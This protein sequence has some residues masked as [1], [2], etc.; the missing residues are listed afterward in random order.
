[1]LALSEAT[2]NVRQG[3]A[4]RGVSV[5]NALRLAAI[6]PARL[7]NLSV[8]TLLVQE[9]MS[10]AMNHRDLSV[11]S[12]LGETLLACSARS[13][14]VDGNR[15]DQVRREI[16][17]APTLR[18][19][20][21]AERVHRGSLNAPTLRAGIP[22]APTHRVGILNVWILLALSGETVGAVTLRPGAEA[23]IL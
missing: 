3:T 5:L 6:R 7:V 9:G 22:N 12:R 2:H 16:L 14:Q 15:S 21:P 13:P 17:S 8:A 11:G 18:A 19:V 4:G 23:V 20:S 10:S 1:M